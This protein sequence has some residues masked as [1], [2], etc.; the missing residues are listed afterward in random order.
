MSIALGLIGLQAVEVSTH[1]SNTI[2]GLSSL[3]DLTA[4]PEETATPEILCV[5]IVRLD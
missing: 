2:V 3:I 5:R 4:N 1:V